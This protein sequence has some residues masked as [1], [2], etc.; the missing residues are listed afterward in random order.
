MISVGQIMK[1]TLIFLL[2]L[3]CFGVVTGPVSQGQEPL[4][5]EAKPEEIPFTYDSKFFTKVRIQE[6]GR[7][8]AAHLDIKRAAI[9]EKPNRISNRLNEE[10]FT[11][12]L[13]MVKSL[14]ASISTN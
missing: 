3:A 1:L 7:A 10:S 11:P 13:K 6:V 4:P 14:I 9:S 8:R 2:A 12:S 5:R